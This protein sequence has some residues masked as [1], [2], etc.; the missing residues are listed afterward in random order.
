MS[1]SVCSASRAKEPLTKRKAV[2]TRAATEISVARRGE[3]HSG[4]G[5]PATVAATAKSAVSAP[6]MQDE[7]ACQVRMRYAKRSAHRVDPAA[8]K[9]SLQRSEATATAS[10]GAT[11]ARNCRDVAVCLC[12]ANSS[13][14]V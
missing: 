2:R 8:V 14:Y 1:A 7:L 12:A 9:G 3:A 10:A 4:L 13:P 11:T 6:S 5:A